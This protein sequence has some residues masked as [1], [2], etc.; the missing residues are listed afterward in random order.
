M[1]VAVSMEGCWT[2]E[3][4]VFPILLHMN[5]SDSVFRF[6]NMRVNEEIHTRSRT[7]LSR[8]APCLVTGD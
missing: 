3:S 5:S 8:S 4:V 6:K 1:V 7:V 2:W